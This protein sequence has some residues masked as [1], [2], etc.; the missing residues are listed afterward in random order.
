MNKKSPDSAVI[1]GSVAKLPHSRI[2]HDEE[3]GYALEDFAG[4]PV[5]GIINTWSD[6]DLP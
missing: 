1:A 4:K 2:V 5:I 6:D 3:M